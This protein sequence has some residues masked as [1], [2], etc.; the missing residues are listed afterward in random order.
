VSR[1]AK[2][3][4]EYDVIKREVSLLRQLVER[5]I[6]R[7]TCDHVHE[8]DDFGGVA[9]SDDDA[10]CIRT[11]VPYEMERVGVEDEGHMAR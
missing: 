1:P 7:D 8:E 10:S 11:V 5:T 4:A 3:F 6:G 9:E 2:P